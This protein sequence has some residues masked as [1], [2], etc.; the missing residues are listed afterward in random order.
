MPWQL[1]MNDIKLY[2]PYPCAVKVNA[3]WKKS[4]HDTESRD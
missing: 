1:W 4:S 3:E 2:K